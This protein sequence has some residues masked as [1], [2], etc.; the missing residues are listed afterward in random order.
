MVSAQLTAAVRRKI[1]FV[2][3]GAVIAGLIAA[4]NAVWPQTQEGV[5]P[6]QNTEAAIDD[7]SYLPPWMRGE[8]LPP[9]AVQAPGPQK[10]DR[11]TKSRAKRERR[12][13][14]GSVWGFFAN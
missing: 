3:R 9:N 4:P 12:Y 8:Y 7:R 6:L 13:A 5:A 11:R 10:P 14:Q 2:A 1:G